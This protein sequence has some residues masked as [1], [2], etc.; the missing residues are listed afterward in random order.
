MA[1]PAG[2]SRKFFVEIIKPSHY[3]D[4]GYVIQWVRAFIPSNSLACL[5]ALAHDCQQRRVLGE[6]VEIRVSAYDECHTVI[7]TGSIIRRIQARGGRGIV[8]LAGV[9]TNQFSRAIDLAREFRAAGIPVAVGGFHVSGCLAM[10]PDLPAEIRTMRELGVTLFAGEAEGRMEGLLADTYHGQLQPIYNYLGDLPELSGQVVPY[11]P[12][13]IA[14]RSLFFAPFDAGRGCPF[15]CSFCTIINVQ[16]RKSRC[17]D[18]DDVERMV[19]AY[20]AQG[21]RRFFITDDNLARNRNWEPIF[22]RL[23]AL[24]EQEG[25]RIKFMIQC[26]TMSHKIPRFIDKATRAGCT[27]VFIGLESVNPKNLALAGK[28]HNHIAHYREMLLA[29]RRRNVLT[30]AGYILGFPTDTP[31][32]IQRDIRLVQR[33]L[34]VDILEFFILTPLPGSADHQA[35]YRQGA[36]LEPDLNQYDLEHVT[37]SHGGMDAQTLQRTYH[38]AWHLYYSPEHVQ[39]LLRRAHAE[40]AGIRHA[41]AA[42]LSYYGSYRCQKLHPLQCGLVRRKVWSTRRPGLPPENRLLFYPRRLWE[43]LTTS[44]SLVWYALKLEWISRQI[45]RDPLAKGYSDSAIV[46][47]EPSTGSSTAPHVLPAEHSRGAA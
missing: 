6:D 36:G 42:I 38:Q 20:A 5:F 23:I 35:L 12:P 13:K 37:T 41:V 7:P 44:A 46:S 11:L 39:T 25:I 31:E 4:A 33:E 1:L 14:G 24:R 17:R 30:H 34:P 45:R 3:D 32:S 22:D 47:D 43:T 29:W 15:E 40:G 27:R 9:Q 21:I 2:C 26:D 19:R 8:L 10:L 18:A 28:L 16:G